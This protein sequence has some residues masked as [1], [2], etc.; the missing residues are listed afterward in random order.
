M[1]NNQSSKTIIV[2][3]A[4]G[5]LGSN[6][7][8]YLL[9]K[10]YRVVGIDSFTDYYSPA[11]KEYNIREFKD[12]PNFTLYRE[13]ITDKEK[14]KEI[15][16]KESPIDTVLHLAAWAG[17][18]E[19]WEKPT[20]YAR[21]NVEGTVVMAEMSVEHD[22]S[23]FI[24]TSTSA[25]YGNNPTPFKEDMPIK[26]LLSPYTATKYSGEMVL[27]PYS[28]NFN[29]PV[30][31]ARIFNPVGKRLRPDLAIPLL[32]R[33]AEYGMEFPVYWKKS[34]WDKTG[35][36]YCY[37]EHIFDA[38]DYLIHNPVD[39]EVFNMGNSSPVSLQ[40]LFD[41]VEKVTGKKLNLVEKPS[42]KGEMFVTYADVSK[43]KKMLGYDPKTKIED[44]VKVFYDWYLKQDENYRMG[45]I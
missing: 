14:M 38:F 41:A 9:K 36:D 4:A 28:F 3:G 12:N 42:R 34:D 18:T 1:Q 43:A 20:T 31:V 16:D 2:T 10:G 40:E 6:L 5:F 25:V 45:E 24:Y 26:D 27:K 11:V 15:F 32:V 17:V 19:S 29:L 33:S 23:S 35:R 39:Y 7:C 37:I 22:V 44:S 8:E 30:A 13:D 21:S